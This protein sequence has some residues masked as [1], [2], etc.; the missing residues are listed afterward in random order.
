MFLL[1]LSLRHVSFQWLWELDPPAVT[2]THLVCPVLL[3]QELSQALCQVVREN[4]RQSSYS[5]PVDSHGVTCDGRTGEGEG[6]LPCA[7]GS[8]QPSLA[9]GPK[10]LD[11]GLVESC[12]G[13]RH[14][15]GSA[16]L[17]C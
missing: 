4:T 1:Y 2:W 7:G 6:Q 14:S 16:A 13:T 11:R 8:Y 15:G 12:G 9:L 3:G 5:A 17:H 10:N